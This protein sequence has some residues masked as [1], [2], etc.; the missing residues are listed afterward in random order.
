[1]VTLTI[2]TTTGA[3]EA[4]NRAFCGVMAAPPTSSDIRDAPAATGMR[5]RRI[6]AAGTAHE[7]PRLGLGRLEGW[8]AMLGL[9]VIAGPQFRRCTA[10]TCCPQR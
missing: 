3:G 10:Y 8:R 5:L 2:W 1:M 7:D 9:V 6:S 4:K